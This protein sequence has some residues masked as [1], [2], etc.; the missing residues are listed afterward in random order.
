MPW[1]TTGTAPLLSPGTV[2]V[3]W[4]TP[5]AVAPWMHERLDGVERQRRD[6]LNRPADRDRFVVG[7]TLLRHAAAAALG[8]DPGSVRIVRRCPDCDRPHGKPALPGTGVE[9]SLA[10]SGDRVGVAVARDTP[11]G[12]DVEQ[13]LPALDPEPLLDSVLGEREAA[14]FAALPTQRRLAAFL[15]Y[16]TR[17]EAVLKATG[18]GLRVS[19][20]RVE[21]T[22]A[23]EPPRVLAVPGADAGAIALLGLDAGAGHV[24]ALAVIG[25]P[26]DHVLELDAAGLLRP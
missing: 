3:W 13:E 11:V 24:G 21:V 9:L 8:T 17:K 18:D 12:L 7:A 5:A 2:Q 14:T 20:R 26:P 1:L 15:T 16:W 6:G 10:H 25:P 23:L 22:G 19:L 4:A